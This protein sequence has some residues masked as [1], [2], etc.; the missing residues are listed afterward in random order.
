MDKIKIGFVPAHREP[1]DEVWAAGMRKRC[2][3]AFSKVPQFQVIVPDGK[4]TDKGLVRDDKDADKTIRLFREKSIAGLIIG[5]M[6]FGDEVSALSIASAFDN[7]PLLIFGTREG[8]F[9][10]QGSRLS[11]S[12]CGT[13]SLSSGLYRRKLPFIFPGIVFPEEDSFLA[14]IADFI[15]VCSIVDGFIGARIGLIGPRPERFETC[16]CNEDAMIQQFKQRVVPVSLLDIMHDVDKPG[17]T[18]SELQKIGQAMKK[19]ADLSP[20]KA[21]TARNISALQY[22]LSNFAEEK[23][24]SAMSVQCWTSMQEV[25]GIASCW[26]MG[27]L[28]DQGIITSCEVDVYGALTMLIQYLASFKKAPPHFI[29]WTIQHQQKENVF[30]SWHCGNAPPSLA[31]KGSDIKIGCHPILSLQLGKDNC[32]GTAEFQLKPGTVT[33]CRLTE[34]DGRFKMLITTGKIMQSNQ[35]LRGSWSWVQVPD[36]K[37]LYS[38]L[39]TQGFTHHAS[40]VHGDYSQSIKEACIFLGIE[41]VIV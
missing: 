31:A 20:I 10:P 11:D 16:I 19:Q 2:L 4:L 34:R 32:M 17:D 1:F 33:L 35:K 14:S 6:T 7:I 41:T 23:G 29:D 27:R 28:T 12:F 3:D 26:A 15:R 9:T 22:A 25:Y 39:V 38:T 5:T 21:K 30:L 36:L 8:D 24:L 37:K 40:M 13:L 18:A